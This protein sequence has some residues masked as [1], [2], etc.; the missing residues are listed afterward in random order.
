MCLEGELVGMRQKAK[1]C[2]ILA[3]IEMITMVTGLVA[4]P[5]EGGNK[6]C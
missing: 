6:V 1:R 2:N 5:M 3:K 4:R